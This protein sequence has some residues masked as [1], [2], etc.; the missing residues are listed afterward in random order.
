MV[1]EIGG[2]RIEFWDDIQA[3]PI[4]VL[5]EFQ[6]YMLHELG[7]GGDISAYSSRT[8]EVQRYIMLKDFDGALQASRNGIFCV[9]YML[10]KLHPGC[11]ALASL[12]RSVDGVLIPA[13]F[14]EERLKDTHNMLIS[15]GINQ[16]LVDEISSDVK[17]KVKLKLSLLVPKMANNGEEIEYTYNVIKR[18]KAIINFAFNGDGESLKIIDEINEWFD[19]KLRP[20]NLNASDENSELSRHARL[21]NDLCNTLEDN[22]VN[23]PQNLTVVEFFSKIQYFNDKFVKLKAHTKQVDAHPGG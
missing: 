19:K 14:T 8:A 15:L 21:F 2:K 13:D 20:L 12:V 18:A 10:K 22:G 9:F 7:I 3:M 6:A 17:K 16:A 5:W 23:M 1:K 4:R 11:M